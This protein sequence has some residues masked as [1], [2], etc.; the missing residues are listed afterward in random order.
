MQANV[1]NYMAMSL[2][3][4]TFIYHHQIQCDIYI[5]MGFLP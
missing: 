5:I 1:S 3:G 2:N 4:D